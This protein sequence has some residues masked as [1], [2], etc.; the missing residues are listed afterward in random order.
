M[1]T[2]SGDVCGKCG[3][4]RYGVYA[5]IERGGLYIRYLRC[6]NCRHTD[7]EIIKS[8]DVRRRRTNTNAQGASATAVSRTAIGPKL[9]FD[10]LQRDKFCCVYCGRKSPDVQLHVDHVVPAAHGGSNEMNNLVSACSEC[11]WGKGKRLA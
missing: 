11:N 6:G 5:N 9:R 7:K 1:A 4:G 2:K 3:C 8:G 10:V